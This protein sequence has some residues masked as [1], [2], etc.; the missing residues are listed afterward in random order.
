MTHVL[1]VAQQS[2]LRDR[3]A[4]VVQS[5]GYV[6]E[7][8]ENSKRG[9]EQAEGN[10]V[11]AALVVHSKDL[12]GPQEP[13]DHVSTSVLSHGTDEVLRPQ[14]SARRAAAFPVQVLDE[15]K[16]LDQIKASP[17]SASEGTQR[18]AVGLR[19]E[20]CQ[21]DLD[22]HAFIDANGREVPL[23]R[24]ETALLAVFVANPCRV[25]SR[26]QLRRAV[27]GH[28]EAEAQ[29]R[30]VDMTVARLRRK[31]E[32]NPKKPRFIRSVPGV[33]YKFAVRPQENGKLPPA[34]H[35]EMG[36]R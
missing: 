14:R 3:I 15:Q 28:E 32:P 20:D 12:N 33:G 26:D 8:A 34:I 2:E 35:L 21:L 4:H 11:E 13:C 10:Q 24:A 1:V 9:L 7:F 19:I 6:V 27:V 5:A 18:T 22:A 25:L 29:G 31:V 23:T 36:A 16:P 30:S 17:G